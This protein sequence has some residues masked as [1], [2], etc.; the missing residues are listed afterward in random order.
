MNMLTTMRDERWQKLA[1][2]F[3][4]FFL[5]KK[6]E[7]VLLVAIDLEGLVLIY[8]LHKEALILGALSVD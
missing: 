1:K 5:I 6:G 2:V 4:F 8:A 7:K 3:C